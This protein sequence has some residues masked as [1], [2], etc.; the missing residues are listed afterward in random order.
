MKK[1]SI[2]FVIL[3]VS[4]LLTLDA[5]AITISENFEIPTTNVTYN[6]SAFQ[7]HHDGVAVLTSDQLGKTGSLWFDTVFDTS[8]DFGINFDFYVGDNTS[9][10][11]GITFAMIDKSL[12]LNAL[13]SGGESLGYFGLGYPS[14]AV[15]FDTY[16]NGQVADPDGNHV[17]VNWQ[18]SIITYRRGLTIN[19]TTLENGAVHN[20][21]IS[22][23]SS[24]KLL[25]IFL[26]NNES[27]N[28]NVEMP[29]SEMY[30]GFTGATGGA[31]NRQYV[32]NVEITGTPAVPPVPEPSTMLLLGFGLIGL[33]GITRKKRKK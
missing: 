11:D 20:A 25:T 19:S 26:N 33:A 21:D 27:W 29:S 5:S 31:S 17:G 9:G 24:T 16:D 13:G 10:A 28:I 30:M 8:N 14:I 2:L 3:S 23:L 7:H 1:A 6:G 12:G 4:L 15:E 22:F 18:T 32:D